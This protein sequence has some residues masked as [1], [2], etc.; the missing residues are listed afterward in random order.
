MLKI[1]SKKSNGNFPLPPNLPHPP[2]PPATYVLH[3]FSLDHQCPRAHLG[4][5]RRAG[6]W[7]RDVL[8]SAHRRARLGTRECSRASSLFHPYAPDHDSDTRPV[9]LRHQRLHDLACL[10]DRERVRGGRIH[11]STIGRSVALGHFT[12]NQLDH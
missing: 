9:H 1:K 7:R 4:R 5:E 8:L 12:C 10:N 11:S 6:I 2:F 3:S